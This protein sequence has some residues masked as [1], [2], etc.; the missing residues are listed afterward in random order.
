MR[1]PCH[2]STSHGSSIWVASYVKLRL[3][4]LA[5][6]L[7]SLF[8][9]L[10][11]IL[12][13]GLLENRPHSAGPI[14][15]AVNDLPREDQLLQVNVICSTVLPGPKEPDQRQLNHCLEL[16]IKEIA[17]LRDGA[18]KVLLVSFFRLYLCL[19]GVKMDVYGEDEQADVYADI[20]CLNCDTPAMRKLGGT[21]GH[22][23]DIHP[24]LYCNTILLDVSQAGG[25][26]ESMSPRSHSLS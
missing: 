15:W 19:A 23:H 25:Y 5:F 2:I 7:L 22:A 4:V 13:F 3:V 11:G 21:T 26:D 24:C 8:S 6:V 14:Y 16:P 1:C 12:R 17:K 20:F 10:M 18:S 9:S